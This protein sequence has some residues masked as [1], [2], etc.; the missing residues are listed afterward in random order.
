MSVVKRETWGRSS[1][2]T[3]MSDIICKPYS[4]MA[5]SIVDT[6]SRSLKV[7]QIQLVKNT[8][9]FVEP[10]ILQPCSDTLDL[11]PILS[12]LTLAHISLFI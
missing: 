5:Q 3:Y 6:Q 10:E 8:L 2:N 1:S 7:E 12:Q 4:R 9:D 11:D